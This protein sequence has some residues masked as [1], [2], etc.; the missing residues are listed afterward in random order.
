MVC[1]NAEATRTAR[2]DPP[3]IRRL[4]ALLG[5]DA[6]AEPSLT[7][8]ALPTAFVRWHK[9]LGMRAKAPAILSRGKGPGCIAHDISG[10]SREPFY[11]HVALA[12]FSPLPQ[13]AS[14]TISR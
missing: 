5:G 14:Q 1:E 3:K 8:R 7:P 4:A 2:P 9:G 6:D 10:G 11:W 12:L 13:S